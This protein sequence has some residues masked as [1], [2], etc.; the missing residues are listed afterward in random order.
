M[1]NFRKD[2]LLSQD[3][4]QLD[5]KPLYDLCTRL[6]QQSKNDIGMY[7]YSSGLETALE[8]LIR[9]ARMYVTLSELHLVLH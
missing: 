1:N 3:D 7:R 9:C 6:V 2:Y 5:W 4:L 8:N